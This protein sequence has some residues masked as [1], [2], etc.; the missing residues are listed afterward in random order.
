M[1]RIVIIGG[2]GKVA[3]HLARL[4]AGRGDEATSVIRTAEQSSDIEAAGGTPVVLDV[5]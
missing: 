1:E 5:E 4:L 3:L 2:H